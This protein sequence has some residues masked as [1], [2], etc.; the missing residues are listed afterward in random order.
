MTR[1]IETIESF[2][3][4]L[5]PRA[6]ADRAREVLGQ[7]VAKG[8]VEL[9]TNSDTALELTNAHP[10]RRITIEYSSRGGRWVAVRDEAGGMAP[11]TLREKF[12]EG[13]AASEPG[14]R[15]NF[16]VG[17]KD[18]A[19][20]G[21]LTVETVDETG[22]YSQVVIPGDYR[23]GRFES[24]PADQADFDRMFGGRAGA[25]TVARIDLAPRGEGGPRLPQ[26]GNLGD[27]L[28]GHFALRNLLL[29]NS[30]LLIDR[31]DES[32]KPRRRRLRSGSPVWDRPD[33]VEKYSG[34]LEIDGN[35]DAHPH[36]RLYDVRDPIDGQLSSDQFEGF[37]VVRTSVAD[38]G[39][40]LAGLE[41]HPHA[42]RLAGELVDDHITALLDQFRESGPTG[43]NPTAIVR[44][45]RRPQEGG[46]DSTH[47][48]S[49]KLAAA[50]YPHV[51]RAL[52][53]IAE[54]VVSAERAGTSA[55]LRA[56]NLEAGSWLGAYLEED[57]GGNR[58]LPEGFYF[59]PP[60][61]RIGPGGRKRLTVY[62]VGGEPLTGGRL[63]VTSDEP[64]I[65][66]IEDVSLDFT[67]PEFPNGSTQFRQRA[68]VEVRAGDALG[69]VALT[70]EYVGSDFAADCE[71]HVVADPP[72]VA[73]FAFE[74]V[75]YGLRPGQ[76]KTVRAVVP[77]DL[78]GN[79]LDSSVAVRVDVGE[80]DL[81]LVGPAVV[82]V[83]GSRVDP[84]LEAYLVS[85]AVEARSHDARGTIHARFK[86]WTASAG[87]KVQAGHL[88][89][90][91]D[92][93][94]TQP[95]DS[96]AVVYGRGLCTYPPEHEGGPCLH[97]FFRHPDVERWLGE[98]RETDDGDV[99]WE[100]VDTHGFRAMK[101]DA[102]AEAAAQY[103]VLSQSRVREATTGRPISADEVLQ[104]YF[105]EKR[106]ALPRMQQ[107]YI[108]GL[109]EPW[110]SQGGAV[111]ELVR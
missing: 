6:A 25:G 2:D 97:V 108:R 60:A 77:F 14:Q 91:D 93:S 31:T 44:Q 88:P 105:A 4:R 66:S 56:A 53:A 39:F 20:L 99:Q 30:V 29:R 9:I 75:A 38:H 71:V 15:G 92:G 83:V 26:I 103:R 104:L 96:R 107:I 79:D 65:V 37:I 61:A 3:Y 1:Q 11:D 68:S 94:E 47:P 111:A 33:A 74:H 22:A 28:S 80:G 40:F 89:V 109:P 62:N 32:S 19:I 41:H 98:A 84:I 7:D 100:L 36:L 46:L 13:G 8:L 95:P 86:D 42:T 78:V 69:S 81:T 72:P 59:L 90:F 17:A 49:A 50:V 110:D 45:D 52:E 102:V 106:H 43:T 57:G 18:C 24:R 76:A 70:A 64:D 10:R 51:M 82:S 87:V 73:D 5:G 27:R 58:E 54:E 85:F 67:E 12:T 21:K 34:E 101:A 35:P 48:Y 55:S 23:N 63:E 16:G